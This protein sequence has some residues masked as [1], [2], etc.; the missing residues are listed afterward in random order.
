MQRQTVQTLL[1]FH[2]PQSFQ[3]TIHP[4]VIGKDRHNAMKIYVGMQAEFQG[5]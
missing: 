2:V 3:L 1:A 4:C 5:S